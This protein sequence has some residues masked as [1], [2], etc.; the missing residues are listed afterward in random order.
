[1]ISSSPP[2][3]PWRDFFLQIL[4]LHRFIFLLGPVGST[5][6]TTALFFLLARAASRSPPPTDIDGPGSP[7]S[8]L[9]S[10]L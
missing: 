1:M 7:L 2:S 9:R 6:T 4:Q 8:D 3:P 10:R 5:K